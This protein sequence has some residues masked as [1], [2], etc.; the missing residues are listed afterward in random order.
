MLLNVHSKLT[1]ILMGITL[2]GCDDLVDKDALSQNPLVGNIIINEIITKSDT[3]ADWIELLNISTSDVD[4]SSAILRDND[5]S[6]TY[7][8]PGNTI[9]PAGAYLVISRDKEGE[10]GFSFGL[11]SEDSVRLFD[12]NGQL[13]DDTHWLAGTV[14]DN[15]SWGRSPNGYGNF[16]ALSVTTKGLANTV[17]IAETHLLDIRTSYPHYIHQD[18]HNS[19]YIF[20]QNELRRYDLWLEDSDLALLDADPAAENYVEGALLFDGQLVSQVGIRYKGSI[21]AFVNCLEDDNWAEPSGEKTCSKLSMKIKINWSDADERFYGL[22]KLQFH[23]QNLDPT[24]MHE[25]LAYWLFGQFDVVAPRSVHAKLY[26]NGEFNGIFALTEQIDEAF[27]KTNFSDGQGNLFKEVWPVDFNGNATEPAQLLAALKTSE[28][29]ADVNNFLLF[30]DAVAALDIDQDEAEIDIMM[31]NWFDIDSLM[32]NIVVDRAIA[33]DDGMYH[34]YCDESGCGNH[35]YY[36]YQA[37]QNNKVFIIPWDLDNAFANLSESKDP[38]T[39]VEDLWNKTSFDC[40]PFPSGLYYLYQRSATCDKLMHAFT[41]YESQYSHL[42]TEFEQQYFNM[43]T[44]NSMLDQ[45]S[46]QIEMATSEAAL[47]HSDQ[48]SVNDWKQAVSTMKSD[49]N[50]SIEN[51]E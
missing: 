15:G 25:R 32:R 6:H 24:K 22:K 38:V 43:A 7:I 11:G 8:L 45:W 37:V 12:Y 28:E 35:N 19:D 31:R 16:T 44:I 18:S 50:R 39:Y 48:I 49:I 33:A 36:W 21:G 30:V 23:S 42:K 9:I 26:I 46:D 14:P 3:E 5:D 47:M 2:F 41:I 40:N 20:D 51:I 4:V 34:W 1:A 17:V 29:Q 27:T 10:T 13:V